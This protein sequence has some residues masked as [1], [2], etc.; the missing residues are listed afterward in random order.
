VSAYWSSL[1][2]AVPGQAASIM[3]DML[4]VIGI[5][6]GLALA[7]RVIAMIRRNV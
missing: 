5:L 3:S 2:G 6:A 4:P 7:E 1:A